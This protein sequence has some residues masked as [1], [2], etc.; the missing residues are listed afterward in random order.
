[1]T[2]EEFMFHELDVSVLEGLEWLTSLLSCSDPW[3]K[4]RG[5]HL[6]EGVGRNRESGRGKNPCPC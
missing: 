2:G 6:T 3:K 5:F 4:A 1:M